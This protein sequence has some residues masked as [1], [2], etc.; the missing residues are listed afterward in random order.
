MSTD[1]G[2]I[3]M[4]HW[5]YAGNDS[6]HIVWKNS[7]A[8][9]EYGIWKRFGKIRALRWQPVV[10]V[11]EGDYED[12]N[13]NS[14][15]FEK[16]PRERS[17]LRETREFRFEYNNI[18]KCGIPRVRLCTIWMARFWTA[19]RLSDCPF[20]R[21]CHRSAIHPRVGA[22]STNQ[23]YERSK[24]SKCAIFLS[25]IRSRISTLLIGYTGIKGD[26][27]RTGVEDRG[28]TEVPLVSIRFVG[29]LVVFSCK[30]SLAFSPN[31]TRLCTCR[32]R[33]KND[34]ELDDK[35]L[36]VRVVRVNGSW[37]KWPDRSRVNGS[38]VHGPHCIRLYHVLK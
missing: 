10:W 6:S 24:H 27:S 3:T 18:D 35:L 22:M 26:S 37:V 8:V 17:S 19:S 11:E 16:T 34:L 9:C 7:N 13:P 20:V 23:K 30:I 15:H 31:Q 4:I 14:K 12:R 25:R 5:F 33:C 21:E 1:N 32:I 28:A 36:S 38:R 2:K 29:V